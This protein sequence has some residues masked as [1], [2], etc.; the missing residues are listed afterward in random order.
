MLKTVS[1]I[2]HDLGIGSPVL[3]VVL[4]SMLLNGGSK[5]HTRRLDH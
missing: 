4:C 5:F 2:S 3:R 1:V